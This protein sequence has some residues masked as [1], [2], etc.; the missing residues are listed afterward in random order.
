M[1]CGYII[2]FLSFFARNPKQEL[3][4]NDPKQK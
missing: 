3:A 1:N 2:Y 4:F